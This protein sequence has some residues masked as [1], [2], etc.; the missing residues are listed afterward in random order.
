MIF[1]STTAE[2]SVSPSYGWRAP[3]VSAGGE[4]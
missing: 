4:G 3:Q 1:E 2:T